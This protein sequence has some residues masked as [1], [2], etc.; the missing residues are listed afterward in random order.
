MSIRVVDKSLN[1]LATSSQPV[2]SENKARSY[3]FIHN[4]SPLYRVAVCFTGSSVISGAGSIT[5]PPGE[6]IE[7]KGIYVPEQQMTAISENA[8][9]TVLTILEG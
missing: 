3:L 7:L 5:I 9:A 6:A 8:S 1:S 4:P 2:L